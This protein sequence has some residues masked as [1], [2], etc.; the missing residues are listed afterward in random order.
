MAHYEEEKEAFKKSIGKPEIRIS[1]ELP[2]GYERQKEEF[3]ELEREEAFLKEA[4]RAVSKIVRKH[5]EKKKEKEARLNEQQL[6]E[7]AEKE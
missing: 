6:T 2:E 3:L 4:E 5:L 1:V 7:K